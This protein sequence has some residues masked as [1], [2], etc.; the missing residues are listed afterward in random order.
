MSLAGLPD[1]AG[2]CQA[3]TGRRALAAEPIGQGRNS[4]VFRVD[5]APAAGA[6]AE[7]VVLKFYR[8]DPGD[9]RDRLG[10]E[11]GALGFLWQ[12]DVRVVPRPIAMDRARN[13][14]VFE[15]I[16]G[17]SAAG[18]DVGVADIQASID[19]L[20]NLRRLSGAEGSRGL[21]AASEACFSIADVVESVGTRLTR[22]EAALA[23]DDQDR[24]LRAWIDR[25]FRPLVADVERW[26]AVSA[27]RWGVAPAAALPQESRTLSPSDFGFHNAVRRPDGRLAFVDFEYFG[28]DDPAKTVSDYLLHPGMALAEDL[29]HRFARG[30]LEAYA[31]V[32]RLRERTRL[33]YP[34]F[35]L[36]W[37]LIILN[38]FLS[39]RRASSSREVRAAQAAKAEALADRIAAQY[40]D[41]PYL[42]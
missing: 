17:R 13:C 18:T 11:F 19:F 36:K 26:V 34:L 41:N 16:D 28:W 40:A 8:R 21:P 2:T 6:D 10:V 37:C 33:V 27:G 29:K 14:A 23:A 25:R 9:G 35:G 24:R 39:E 32:S 38:D 12:N 4:R 31:D 5:L 20:A 30:C 15:F 42:V 22:L 3:L 1:A 7:S